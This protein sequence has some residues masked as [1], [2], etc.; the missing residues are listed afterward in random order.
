MSGDS[1]YAP[2]AARLTATGIISDPWFE[3]RPR[4]RSEPILLTADTQRALYRAAED[5]AEAI[6]E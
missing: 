2:F 3:G 4:F 5:M 6:N 1:P